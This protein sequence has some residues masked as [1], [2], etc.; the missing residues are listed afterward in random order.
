MTP[1]ERVQTVLAGGTPDRPPLFDL[2]RNRA[3]LEHYSGYKLYDGPEKCVYAAVRAALDSTRSIRLPDEP[4]EFDLG[5]GRR[6]VRR[7][8]TTWIVRDRQPDTEEIIEDVRTRVSDLEQRLQAES[9]QLREEAA[10]TRQGIERHLRHL[11]PDFALIGPGSSVGMMMYTQW[12][13]EPFCYAVAEEPELFSDYWELS[14]EC[15]VRRIG[16]MEITDLVCG[17][18]CGEDIAYKSGTLFSL[19]FLRKEYFP[20]FH[21]IA[22]A[23]HEKGLPV[24]FHSDG[25]LMW[26]L[27]DLAE[28]EIDML[29]P[30]EVLAGM[31]PSEIRQ[32]FPN[33]VLVG[34]IDVSQ[35][36][37]FGSPSE[38]AAAT[39][40]L[41]VD[42]GPAVMIG[43]STELHDKVP[44]QNYQ[45]MAETVRNWRY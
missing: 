33:L 15:A 6:Q 7:E 14:T 36:L 35:L 12:G 13:L 8:W 37:P 5:D 32:R 26:I 10:R 39:R 34:G 9:S 40:Q 41:I 45:A 28:C 16:F 17:V 24:M 42:A 21:R 30:I 20:R 22:D 27:D 11:G 2:L 38:V 25:N 23:F 18:F 44:L 4:G 19:D 3:V 29:N 43:S 31:V 1:K